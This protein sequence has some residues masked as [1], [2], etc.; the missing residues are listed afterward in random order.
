M[1]P[2]PLT[3]A[4]ANA[5]I[6]SLHRHHKPVVGHRFTIGAETADGRVVGA[7]VVGRPVAHKTEQYRIAE[8]TRLVT[9][10]T[11]NAC[12]LLY[13]ATARAAE[14]MGQSHESFAKHAETKG[15]LGRLAALPIRVAGDSH[16]HSAAC[17]TDSCPPT[18]LYTCP[19]GHCG[20]IGS[21]GEPCTGHPLPSQADL[22]GRR[23][24]HLVS[25]AEPGTTKT[26]VPM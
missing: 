3:L 17:T 20:R 1:R 23:T 25:V 16:V 7:A 22:I 10:G 19:G 21:V 4:Q 14:A 9:D 8:V 6:A 18:A 2:I 26:E 15:L 5:L 12:S 24:R 13:G 11:R